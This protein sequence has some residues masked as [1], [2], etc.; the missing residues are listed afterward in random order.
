MGGRLKRNFKMEK[1]PSK[2]IT[3]GYVLAERASVSVELYPVSMRIKVSGQSFSDPLV[4]VFFLH[5]IDLSH[6]TL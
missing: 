5:R 6:L 2:S 3:W 1:T 4:Y